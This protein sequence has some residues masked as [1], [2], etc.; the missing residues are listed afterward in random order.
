MNSDAFLLIRTSFTYKHDKKMLRRD[1]RRISILLNKEGKKQKHYEEIVPSLTRPS[2]A[3]CLYL[4]FSYFFKSLLTGNLSLT[5]SFCSA[6]YHFEHLSTTHAAYSGYAT[7]P[8]LRSLPFFIFHISLNPTF[9]TVSFGCQFVIV[10]ILE[11]KI[12]SLTI[13]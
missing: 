12:S 9:H 11:Y 5:C 7:S 13:K 1:T 2:L 6:P 4:Y 8:I 3:F 10:L